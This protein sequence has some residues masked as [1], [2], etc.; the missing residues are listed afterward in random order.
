M[1]NFHV[2]ILKYAR[3][4]I[5]SEQDTFICLPIQFG[6]YRNTNNSQQ[7][8]KWI[9]EQIFPHNTL[10]D[11]LEAECK[12]NTSGPQRKDRLRETRLRWIDWMIENHTIF[13]D[14]KT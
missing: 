6:I 11:W 8:V 13:D 1:S 3:N 2:V 14:V 4:K 5:E 9:S 12:I 10:G 7:I